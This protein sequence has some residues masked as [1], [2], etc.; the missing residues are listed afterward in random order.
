MNLGSF[1]GYQVQRPNLVVR[2]VVTPGRHRLARL[3]IVGV[4]RLLGW[5]WGR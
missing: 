4:A 1:I 5:M 2:V 3:A